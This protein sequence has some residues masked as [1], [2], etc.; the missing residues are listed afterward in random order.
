MISQYIK[1]HERKCHR[2]YHWQT[3]TVT[4]VYSSKWYNVKAGWLTGISLSFQVFDIPIALRYNLSADDVKEAKSKTGY[5]HYNDSQ[6]T[7]VVILDNFIYFFK[8]PL[9]RQYDG[10]DI[11]ERKRSAIELIRK[12][13]DKYH[14]S[15]FYY[16]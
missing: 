3:R 10:H 14:G 15:H 9:P 5:H 6:M 7:V 4:H 13:H 2:I 11:E 12:E 16:G 1:S 8:A